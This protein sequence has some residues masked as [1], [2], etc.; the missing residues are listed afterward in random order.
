MSADDFKKALRETF[1]GLLTDEQVEE[2]LNRY[3][4][5][6][7]LDCYNWS[8]FLHDTENGRNQL[9]VLTSKTNIPLK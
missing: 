9:S 6:D 3:R 4:M 2:L 1:E 5:V 7:S 8:K